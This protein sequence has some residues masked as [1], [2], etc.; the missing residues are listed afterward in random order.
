MSV[1]PVLLLGVVLAMTLAGCSAKLPTGTLQSLSYAPPLNGSVNEVYQPAAN[2]NPTGVV[3]MVGGQ[4]ECAQGGVP[5][6]PPGATNPLAPCK[7][8]YSTFDAGFSGLPA[9]AGS[10][11]KLY[12]VGP[13]SELDLGDLKAGTATGSYAL[14]TNITDR[15]VHDK[16]A[17]LQLRMDGFVLATAPGTQGNH[18]FA[19]AE[20]IARITVSGTFTGH[21]LELTVS[22]LPGNATYMGKLYVADAT[23]PTGFSPKEDF[24]VH[25][26][27]TTY[28]SKDHAIGDFAQFHIH[29]GTSALN[30]YKGSFAL[31]T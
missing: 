21:H 27:T 18:T 11:Y 5:V 17:A 19:L 7:G 2:R 12:A 9:P 14:H 29:V 26:G 15:D 10:G 20:P 8:P 13:G 3:P 1:R 30:L 31:A 23:N 25:E 22:G 28:D 4:T 16:V 6:S 24:P